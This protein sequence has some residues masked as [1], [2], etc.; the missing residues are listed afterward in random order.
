MFLFIPQAFS[1]LNNPL[2]STQTY[3]RLICGPD[4]HIRFLRNSFS[5]N[6]HWI[7]NLRIHECY[8]QNGLSS[9]LLENLKSLKY[10]TIDGLGSEIE[11]SV[12]HDAL[13]GLTNL[14]ILAI[15]SPVKDGTLPAGLFEGL[16]NLTIIKLI[17]TEFDCI[18]P[19]SFNGL[20]K[21]KI[22]ELT[23]NNLIALPVGLFDELGSLAK[24]DLHQNPWHCTCELRWLTDWTHLT[25][26]MFL[27]LTTFIPSVVYANRIPRLAYVNK[28]THGLYG[29][30]RLY[31]RTRDYK[32]ISC[33]AQLS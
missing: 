20:V 10:F 16:T 3:L 11:G 1:G 18:P 30:Y 27:L 12:A 8:I 21:L 17:D 23:G 15:R 22:I 31:T 5:S 19:N 6:L 33:S 29:L 24:V 14:Q 7:V 4:G 28:R 2:I 25:G 13:T 26:S 9:R 32:N